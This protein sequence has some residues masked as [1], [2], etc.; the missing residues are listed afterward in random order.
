MLRLTGVDTS[1]PVPQVTFNS[2]T[3]ST[4]TATGLTTSRDNSVV[5]FNAFAWDGYPGSNGSPP[6][7]TSPTFTERFD[8]GANSRYVAEGSLLVAGATGDKTQ[9]SANQSANPWLAQLIE[10]QSPT[11]T[12]PAFGFAYGAVQ[13]NSADAAGTTYNIT[14]LTFTPKALRFYWMGLGSSS[15]AVSGATHQR[16]GIGFAVSNSDRRCVGVQDQDAA[17]NM[18]CTTGYRTDCVAMTL[19]STPAADGLLD[20]NAIITGGF[21]LIVDDAAPANVTVFWEAWGGTDIT[22]AKTV[23]IAEPAATGNQDVT[24]TGFTNTSDADQVVMFAGC[25]ATA[26]APTAARN[27]SGLCVGFVSSGGGLSVIFV[28]NN[29]DGSA[30]ADCDSYNKSGE[31]LAM[32]TVAGGNPDARASLNSWGTDKFT[33]NWLARAV[34]GRK[35]IGLAIKGG[36]WKSSVL[37][38][39]G[40]TTTATATLSGLSFTPVGACFMARR[41][42]ESVGSTAFIHNIMSLGTATGTTS[43]QSMGVLVSDGTA[44]CEVNLVMEY[45]QVICTPNNAGATNHAL[46]INAWNSDGFQL[47]NDAAGSANASELVGYLT[48][49]SAPSTQEAPELKG[50]PY[51]LHG[52]QQVSQLIAQ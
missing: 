48:F 7:G 52:H 45:D 14:N 32:I 9:S 28:G 12:E 41:T 15:D 2:G 36:R 51:G 30:A 39:D 13:W 31:C 35:Y 42:E 44:A 26:A 18:T 40:S 16:A 24:V 10:V 4:T 29:D 37:T 22:V 27:D 5:I 46:D 34:T 20:L 11:L 43:R 17:A 49:G 33:L 19:T 1:T 38:I 47:I 25:Q 3:G 23:E 8:G 21:Q 6:T 50:R